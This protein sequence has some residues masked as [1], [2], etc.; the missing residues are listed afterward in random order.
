MDNDKLSNLPKWAQM[1][2]KKL[3]SDIEYHKKKLNE[4]YGAVKTN[5]YIIDGLDEQP[6]P[7]DSKIRFTFPD[8]SYITAY[9]N[10]ESLNVFGR[11]VIQIQPMSGNYIEITSE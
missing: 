5:C 11:G 3:E 1:R 2:I 10:K 4:F 8:G 6:L 7:Q 9:P